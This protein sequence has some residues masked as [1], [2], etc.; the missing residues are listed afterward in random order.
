MGLSWQDGEY[1]PWFKDPAKDGDV[2][3][4]GDSKHVYTY[5]IMC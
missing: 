1:L 4:S 5:N 3:G 2:S